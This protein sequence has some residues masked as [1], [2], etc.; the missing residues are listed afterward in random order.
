MEFK[1]QICTTRE[2]SEKLLALG[3]K[4]ETA[5]LTLHYKRAIE[6]YELQDIP[7]SR[8]V[9]LREQLN[10]SPI[11]GRSG[12][13]LYAKDIPAWSLHRLMELM[14]KGEMFGFVGLTTH[15]ENIDTIYELVIANI[16]EL[17]KIDKFN[18]DYLED[19]K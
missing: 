6:D 19:K 18:K 4:K 16:E 7:F 13:D 12:D 2:Q 11:L 14:H 3:L 9:R 5:D 15:N 10:K 8:I 17:I 1:S